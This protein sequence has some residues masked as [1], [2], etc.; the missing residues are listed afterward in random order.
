[1]A[2]MYLPMLFRN[3]LLALGDDTIGPVTAYDYHSIN[4]VAL[5]I[6]L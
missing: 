1:M 4:K 2:T 5:K 3:D 6:Y